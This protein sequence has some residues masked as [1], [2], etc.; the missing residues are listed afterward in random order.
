MLAI[1]IMAIFNDVP[2]VWVS[3]VLVPL[4]IILRG[5]NSQPTRGPRFTVAMVGV[6]VLLLAAFVVIV[7]VA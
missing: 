6:V 3:M 7:S 4:V 2:A 1:L 5:N